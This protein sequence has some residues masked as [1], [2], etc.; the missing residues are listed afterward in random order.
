MTLFVGKMQ[1]AARDLIGVSSLKRKDAFWSLP[2]V[3]IKQ[4]PLIPSYENGSTCFES[5]VRP[6]EL[7]ELLYQRLPSLPNLRVKNFSFF[8]L[9][10]SLGGPATAKRQECKRGEKT[11]QENSCQGQV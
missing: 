11:T 5:T 3:E 10:F 9:P 4:L 8:P 6:D 7:L 2:V 1:G